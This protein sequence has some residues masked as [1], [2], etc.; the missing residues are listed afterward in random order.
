MNKLPGDWTTRGTVIESR[1]S[2]RIPPREVSLATLTAEVRAMRRDGL[3]L[4]S[5][6]GPTADG[7][8]LIVAVHPSL[9]A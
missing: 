4:T 3:V 6:C 2:V 5:E 8:Y 9:I 7:W 1:R